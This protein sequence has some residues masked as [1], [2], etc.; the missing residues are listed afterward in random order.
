MMG[1][2]HVDQA[3]LFY[4]FS[5]D[6]PISPPLRRTSGGRPRPRISSP[7]IS[8]MSPGNSAPVSPIPLALG[9]GISNAFS[10]FTAL[11]LSARTRRRL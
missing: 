7:A 11:L 8:P 4:K 1:S 6:R 2:R 3:S 9:N 10:N 5:L